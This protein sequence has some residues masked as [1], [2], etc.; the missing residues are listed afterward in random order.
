V[1]RDWPRVK[2]IFQA[3]IERAPGTRAAFVIEECGGDAALRAEVER[4]VAAHDRAGSF[5]EQSPAAAREPRQ[6]SLAGRVIGRYEIGRL[7]GAGGMG[8]VYAARDLELGRQVAIKIATGFDADAQTRLRREAQHASQLN[9]PHIC[10]IHEVGAADGQSYIVMEYVDGQRLS[11]VIPPNGLPSDTVVRYG[12]Q[13]ADALAHAHRHSVT[14]RD[15]K[16]ANIVITSEGRAKVLDF[17]LA[18]RNVPQPE[19]SLTAEGVVAGTLAYMAPE[20]LRGEQANACSDIWALGVVLYEMAA[21][22]RPFAGATGF[23]QSGAILHEPP[24]PLPGRVPAPLQQIIRR[25]L[26][27]DPRERYKQANEVRS[28]LEIAQV[29]APASAP[30]SVP[31]ALAAS[32]PAV[33]VPPASWTR[34]LLKSCRS[35]RLAWIGGV[36]LAIILLANLGSFGP[37]STR[38]RNNRGYEL[39]DAGH[40]EDAMREFEKNVEVAPREANSYDS[41]GEGY[42]VMGAPDTAATYYERALAIDPTYSPSRTG[43]AWA[44]GMLGRF[45]RAIADDPPDAFVKA[46]LLS[47]VGRY[48]E[49][50]E[51]LADEG[52]KASTLLLASMLA[53]ERGDYADAENDVRGAENVIADLGE[54]SRRLYSVLADLLGGTAAA[55]SGDAKAAHARLASQ[56]THYKATDPTEK[57]WHQA[58]AAEIALAAADPQAALDAYAAGEPSRKMWP[59]LRDTSMVIFANSLS[60]RDVPARAQAARGDLH[61]AT[62]TYRRLLTAGPEQKFAAVYEPRYVLEMARLLNRAGDNGAAKQ[63]YQRFLDFWK[64]ADPG[65]PEVAEA[66]K[67]VASL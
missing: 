7:L 33:T 21:G 65:L 64:N 8:Q 54:E 57:W 25:C 9:H 29:G 51:V 46:L 66:R 39:L 10:T 20:L 38:I 11:D 16:T 3:A 34:R 42:L 58:L 47:R 6:A 60:V 44:F 19:K 37:I 4:L 35:R 50:K 56:A 15:L 48:E 52:R 23:E 40:P 49:T 26:A 41:L 36:T 59:N 55:R 27:K 53:T 28:A 22:S 45:D 5:I 62:Q 1:T 2:E 18:R 30:M 32:A 17:G 61:G 24:A 14:H 63:E 13:I 43:R 67:M 12:I 31:S